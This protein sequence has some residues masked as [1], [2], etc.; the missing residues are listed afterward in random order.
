M[1]LSSRS[2]DSVAHAASN[3]FCSSSVVAFS[4]PTR[5]F[6]SISPE[7]SSAFWE[8]KPICS[9]KVDNAYDFIGFPSKCISPLVGSNKRGKSFTSVDFP[10]PVLPMR[11]IVCPVF[12][13]KVMFLR[14]SSAVS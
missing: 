6:F 11:P 14:T 8:V 1:P 4:L 13:E 3:A 10:L 9:R 2:T 5:I 7:N 12:T